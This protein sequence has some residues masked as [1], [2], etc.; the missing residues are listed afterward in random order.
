ML[1]SQSRQDVWF[2]LEARQG[3]CLMQ[4]KKTAEKA[5]RH[6]RKCFT[7]MMDRPQ[8]KKYDKDACRMLLKKKDT[9]E[10]KEEGEECDWFWALLT[11]GAGAVQTRT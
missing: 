4:D 2:E 10:T 1:T 3:W 11:K 8:V 5:L 6:F 9:K 7:F